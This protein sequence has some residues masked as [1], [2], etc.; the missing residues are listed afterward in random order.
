MLSLHWT[1]ADTAAARIRTVADRLASIEG[2]TTITT[3]ARTRATWDIAGGRARESS[4]S[5]SRSYRGGWFC[6]EVLVQRVDN[7]RRNGSMA[8]LFPVEH[9]VSAWHVYL[10]MI[11]YMTGMF[12]AINW[13]IQKPSLMAFL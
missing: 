8:A 4:W 10:K 11:F 2:A 9:V 7:C 5:R 6:K 12:T 1:N 3:P 13:S